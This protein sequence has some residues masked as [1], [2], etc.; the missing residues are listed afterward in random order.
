MIQ[1]IKIYK[2]AGILAISSIAL[3]AEGVVVF[4][5]SNLNQP[6]GDL[7]GTSEIFPPGLEFSASAFL[8]AIF[9]IGLSISFASIAWD[10]Q[11]P[12]LTMGSLVLTFFLG[13]F[14]FIVMI[15][16]KPLF[17]WDNDV[18]TGLPIE[19]AG[20]WDT[21]ARRE[22]NY[23]MGFF[24]P[25]ICVAMMSLGFQFAS[26]HNLYRCQ[27]DDLANDNWTYNSL[28]Y[29]YQSFLVF[30]IGIGIMTVAGW[31]HVQE[32]AGMLQSP[33]VYPP[34]IIKYPAV[35]IITGLAVVAYGLVNT[36]YSV[37]L[38]ATSQDIWFVTLFLQLLSVAA[39]AI[40]VGFHVLMQ[41]ATISPTLAGVGAQYTLLLIP[42]VFAPVYYMG[43]VLSAIK[44]NGKAVHGGASAKAFEA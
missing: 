42:I 6:E 37:W 27:T 18:R 2:A 39:Y 3:A 32:G 33:V 25:S 14:Y 13:W 10:F 38:L 21:E 8:I 12:S 44:N 26:L 29:L 1:K 11:M 5:S 16:A 24:I 22:A 4:I 35:A 19:P 34:T 7:G 43:E 20:G 41:A 28:R 23:F 15:V 31:T 30:W 40:L 36:L 9:T 17:N